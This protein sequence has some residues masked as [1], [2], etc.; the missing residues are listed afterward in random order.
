MIGHEYVGVECQ[1][2]ALA[3]ALQAFEIG[4]VIRVVMK[5]RCAAIAAGD[6]M[7]ECA[8]YIEPWFAAM[9]GRVCGASA[10]SQNSGLTPNLCGN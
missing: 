7:I 2:I 5:D 10:I 1:P 6:H 3:I 8:R 9:R 4:A